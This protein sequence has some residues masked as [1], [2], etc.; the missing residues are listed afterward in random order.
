LT[1]GNNSNVASKHQKQ[2]PPN[3]ASSVLFVSVVM[4]LTGPAAHNIAAPV[5]SS[6]K[7]INF[8]VQMLLI[9]SPNP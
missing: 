3:V 7:K 4:V 5:T 8:I 9:L 2:P 1:P 6:V